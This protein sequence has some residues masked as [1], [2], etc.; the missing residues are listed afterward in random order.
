M[1]ER[2]YSRRGEG[3]GCRSRED[4]RTST[5]D[6]QAPFFLETFYALEVVLGLIWQYFKGVERVLQG[7]TRYYTVLHSITKYYGV[8]HSITLYYTVLRGY[9]TV[10]LASCTGYYAR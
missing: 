5:A 9:Y 4:L 6:T 7:I 10:L 8:L 1:G 2:E 3:R